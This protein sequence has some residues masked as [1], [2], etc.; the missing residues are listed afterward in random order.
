MRVHGLL[1]HH[2]VQ[3]SQE[4]SR[5]KRETFLSQAYKQE[6]DQANVI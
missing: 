6:N 5:T 1:I 4:L 2:R 3:K